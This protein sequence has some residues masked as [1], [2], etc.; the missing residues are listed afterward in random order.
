MNFCNLMQLKSI[1][2]RIEN[3]S[4]NDML[5][6]SIV[7]PMLGLVFVKS[8]ALYNIRFYGPGIKTSIE[9]NQRVYLKDESDFSTTSLAI[10]FF[11]SENGTLSVSSNLTNTFYHSFQKNLQK[12]VTFLASEFVKILKSDFQYDKSIYE[13]EEQFVRVDKLLI[14]EDIENKSIYDNKEIKLLMI[15]SF[16]I[17][18]LDKSE[19]IEM[20]LRSILESISLDDVDLHEPKVNILEEMVTVY[21]NEIGF[22]YSKENLPPSNI[23]IP[24]YVRNRGTYNFD[25]MFPDCADVLLLNICN[26]L[27][28]DTSKFVFSLEHLN[29]DP[30]SDIAVFYG[31]HKTLFDITPDIR[32]EWSKVVQ[33]LSDFK[34]HDTSDFRTDLIVYKID[35]RNEIKS[36]FINMMNALIKICNINHEKFWENINGK[37]M[38]ECIESKLAELLQVISNKNIEV[39][40]HDFRIFKSID[41]LDFTGNAV[42]T[43]RLID[44]IIKIIIWHVKYHA[45][46]SIMCDFNQNQAKNCDKESPHLSIRLLKLLRRQKNIKEESATDIFERIYFTGSI[47]TNEQKRK[48]LLDIFNE[49]SFSLSLSQPDQ[50]Q[51]SSEYKT[52][53]L[54]E[55]V[56]VLLD[57]VALND[58]GTRREFR[59]F[60]CNKQDLQKEEVIESWIEC[61]TI[62]DN[63]IY[64]LWSERIIAI[65]S[66]SLNLHVKRKISGSRIIDLFRTLKRCTDLKHLEIVCNN[67]KKRNANFIAEGL[68]MLSFLES[69]N[70]SNNNLSYRRSKII[71]AVLKKMTSLKTLDISNCS[72]GD[73]EMRNIFDSIVDLP[74]LTSISINNNNISSENIDY[75]L[76]IASN[77][78]SLHHFDIS[79]NKLSVD[80][81]NTI[82]E[83]FNKQKMAKN[84]D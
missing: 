11:P 73:N 19:Y 24:S 51:N 74:N 35:D 81:L 15:H 68:K 79:N 52:R 66:T 57:S 47:K 60:L 13:N 23:H 36:G 46:M 8:G 71:A 63:N 10:A 1:L 25:K 53:L 22:P 43:F 56:S 42:V 78:T 37:S 54:N 21:Q 84:V 39:E 64:K 29:L 4:W 41:R 50:I 48:V 75:L 12:G 59:H 83:A 65:N 18:A 26:C 55:V 70:F 82:E 3:E 33:G 6:S 45:E 2:S 49:L 30:D 40:T 17:S 28:Y 44:R 61:L 76:N 9:K 34:T 32:N 31:K 58:Q 14:D 7:N 62:D 20:Y 27:F 80:E 69:L 5:Y 72:I 77:M 67:D 16:I 38:S